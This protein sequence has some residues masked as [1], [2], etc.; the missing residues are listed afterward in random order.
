MQQLRVKDYMVTRVHT[1][2]PD[3]DMVEAIAEFAKLGI[4]GA[5]VVDER[6][7]LLGMLSDTDCMDAML[8]A[9]MDPAWRA[10]VATYMTTDVETVDA[11]SSLIDVA[12]RFL[13]RRFRRFPVV[14]DNQ[15][16]GQISRLDVLKAIGDIKRGF[17]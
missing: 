4:S 13:E 8:K 11:E 17:A 6:R 5:P 14:D 16:V 7:N 1:L 3:R 9:G 15:L 10:S 12:Q 2:E